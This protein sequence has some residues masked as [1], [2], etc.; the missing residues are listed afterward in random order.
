MNNQCVKTFYTF[1]M[2]MLIPKVIVELYQSY[3]NPNIIGQAQSN[4][5]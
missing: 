4:T 1:M 3:I 2:E 5:K